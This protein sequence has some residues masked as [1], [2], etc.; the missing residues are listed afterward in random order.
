[1]NVAETWV[2]VHADSV[3]SLIKH[4]ALLTKTFFIIHIFIW[5]TLQCTWNV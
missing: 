1:M 5:N 2:D 4:D 3:T